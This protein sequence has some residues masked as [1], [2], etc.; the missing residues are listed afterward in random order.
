MKKCLPFL[1]GCAIALAASGAHA[2]ITWFDNYADFATAAAGLGLSLHDASIGAVPF[3]ESQPVGTPLA[4]NEFLG[5]AHPLT[6]GAPNPMEVVSEQTGPIMVDGRTFTRGLGSSSTDDTVG[7]FGTEPLSAI[8]VWVVDSDT[9]YSGEESIEAF[10][11]SDNLYMTDA[12]DNGQQGMFLGSVPFPYGPSNHGPTPDNIHFVGVIVD[13]EFTA[14]GSL[15][16]NESE[17]PVGARDNVAYD[18]VVYSTDIV[19]EPASMALVGLGTL[20]LALLRRR[21]RK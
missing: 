19:P 2:Q 14:I 15:I 10:G 1:F 20:G 18:G 9:N 13:N 4:G 7:F 8:G 5:D 17:E 3:W 12:R 16:F 11:P 6:Y 21:R